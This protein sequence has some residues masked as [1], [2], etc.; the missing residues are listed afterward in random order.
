MGPAS[1]LINE[2]K[3]KLL[4]KK[5]VQFPLGCLWDTDMAAV[6]LFRNTIWPP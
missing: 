2:S 5:R 3:R 4:H 6:L 1:M